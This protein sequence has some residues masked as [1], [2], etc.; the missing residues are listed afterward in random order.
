MVQLFLLLLKMEKKPH[1]YLVNFTK[2]QL[3][4]AGGGSFF[5]ST[6]VQQ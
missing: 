3:W 5:Y 6:R 1:S 4:C 2:W